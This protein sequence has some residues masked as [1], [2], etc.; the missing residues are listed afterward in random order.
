MRLLFRF[1]DV[2]EGSIHFDGQNISQVTQNSLRN[3]IGVVPQDTVL[4][5]DTIEE[6]IKYAKPGASLDEV[7]SASKLA[8]IHDKI[9]QFPDGYDT[10][11]G[12]RGL[13]LSGGEKQRVAIARTLLKSPQVILLDEATSALDSTTEKNIQT[14]LNQICSNR[15]TLVIAHRLSTITHANLILVLKDGEIVQR[16]CHADLLQDHE[17]LYKELWEQQA[18]V[19]NN[20]ET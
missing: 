10:V 9:V 7:K 3:H 19:K 1:F 12:E 5:N 11:V 8:E 17:G 14:A 2:K 13:K 4:F 15:T 6:N 16:G 18:Q 20:A